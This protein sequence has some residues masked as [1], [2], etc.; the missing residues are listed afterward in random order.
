M[1]SN[2]LELLEE[3][4]ARVPL[5]RAFYDDHEALSFA[6]LMERS[7]RIGSSLAAVT[8]PRQVVALLLDARSIR[9]LPAIFGVLYAGCAYA[10]RCP[11]AA[12]ACARARPEL[13][14][15]GGHLAACPRAFEGS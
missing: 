12:E 4:A 3:T 11:W 14:G 1:K 6:S 2:I 15:E 8:R 7:R 10:P 9:N 5:R 13:R